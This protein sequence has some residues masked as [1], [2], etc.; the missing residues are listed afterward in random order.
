M[1]LLAFL[2]SLVRIA[3]QLGLESECDAVRLYSSHA[4]EPV[5]HCLCERE[6]FAEY[7]NKNNRVLWVVEFVS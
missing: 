2:Y 1:T 7:K 5:R 3:E 6:S 4:F